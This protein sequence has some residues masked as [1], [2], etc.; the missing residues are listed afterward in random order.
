AKLLR[1]VDRQEVVRVGENEPRRIDARVVAATHVDVPRM[2][3]AGRFREDL[4]YRIS[5]LSIEIPSLRERGEDEVEYLAN[6]FLAEHAAVLQRAL[7]WSPAAMEAL[8]AH[9]WPGNVR[10]LKAVVARAIVMRGGD[11]IE[12]E[13]LAL[14]VQPT[15]GMRLEERARLGTY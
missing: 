13:A 5:G 9:R 14:R 11:S 10:E 7:S 6:A 1:V 8:R 4:Y 15:R 2:V 3:E 12:P